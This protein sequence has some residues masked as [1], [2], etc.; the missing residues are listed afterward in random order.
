MA[1]TKI[2]FKMTINDEQV[3][4][5]AR[6]ILLPEIGG[7]GQKKIQ[8][9]KVL[10]V[11]AGGLGT[12]VIQYLAAAGVGTIGIIDDDIVELSNLQR[13]VIHKTSQIGLAKVVSAKI[14]A[15][16]INPNINIIDHEIRLSPKNSRELISKYDIIS[17][18]SDN[19]ST[20][21]LVMD[22]CFLEKKTLV[23]GAILRFDGQLSVFKPHD[24]SNGKKP[25][26]RCIYPEAPPIDSIPTCAQA[27]VL[28]ALCGIIGSLQAAEILKE[29]TGAGESLAGSLMIF[30]GLRTEFRKIKVNADPNCNLCSENASIKNLSKH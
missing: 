18:G 12:P 16:E 2:S 28:G 9:A 7:A 14:S 11:G 17:D 3:E 25:C 30:D 21:F 23:S 15:K 10:I 1:L 20:R 6:H 19:F 24:Y 13:Q 22:S 5:Y 8:R 26:Y 29:I 4:R 27:G